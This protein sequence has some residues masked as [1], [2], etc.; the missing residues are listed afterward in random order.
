MT[1]LQREILTY[2][3]QV[4]CHTPVPAGFMVDRTSLR[5]RRHQCAP[6]GNAGGGDWRNK[7]IGSVLAGMKKKGLVSLYCDYPKT[8]QI[9]TLG[10]ESLK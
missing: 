9:T 5:G 7:T 8:W 4:P 2:L 1:Q 10:I 6:N 3:D